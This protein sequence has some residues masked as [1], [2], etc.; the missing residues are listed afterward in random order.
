MHIGD[1]DRSR[2]VSESTAREEAGILSR[3][4]MAMPGKHSMANVL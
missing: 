1:K 2:L 4:E 3:R